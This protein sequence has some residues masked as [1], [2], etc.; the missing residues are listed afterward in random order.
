LQ[1][2]AARRIYLLIKPGLGSALNGSL[3]IVKHSPIALLPEAHE[4]KP[5]MSKVALIQM[6][7]AMTSWPSLGLSLLK[8]S[9]RARGILSEVI[10]LN[11]GFETLVGKTAY[12]YIASGSPCN[13]DLLGE[14]T[15]SEALWEDGSK[16]DAAYWEE[17]IENNHAHFGTKISESDLSKA[18]IYGNLCK[19]NV[20]AFLDQS[21]NDIEWT[22]YKIVGFTSVF[23]QH[24]ASLAFARLLKTLFPHLF[25][26]FGGANCEAEMGAATLRCFPFIDAVCRGE[27]DDIFPLLA[28]GVLKNSIPRLD[29]IL[30]RDQSELNE[31]IVID[32]RSREAKP[33]VDLNSLPY[34]DFDDFFDKAPEGDS[35]SN[36]RLVF[37]T[38]RGCWWGQKHHCT[39][40]GLNG[41]GMAFRNKS[42]ARALEELKWMLSRY[43]SYTRSVNATDNIM[44]YEFFTSFLPELAKLDFDLDLF[45]ET[46]ANLKVEQ[47]EL[48][49]RAGLSRIQPGIES[50]SS[51]V[52]SL[53]EKGVTALQ[54]I[55]LLKLCYELD[56]HPQWNYLYGFPGEDPRWYSLQPNLIDKIS[57]LTPPVGCARVRFDRFSQ[58]LNNPSKFGLKQTQPYA[59]Y[60]RIYRGVSARDLRDLAYYF[61]AS[62]EGENF[63]EK[64]TAGASAA[65]KRWQ[66]RNRK[67]CLF[68]Q[69]SP[70]NTVVYDSRGSAE[71]DVVVLQGTHHAV[72]SLCDRI[73]SYAEV[74]RGV[75]ALNLEWTSG[76]QVENAIRD[77]EERNLLISENSKLLGLSVP[78]EAATPVTS[79][80]LASFERMFEGKKNATPIV[81]EGVT[82]LGGEYEVLG[83]ETDRKEVIAN[84]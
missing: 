57:H 8:S 31:L 36:L 50:L 35:A 5:H 24:V 43:G 18:R 27:G 61:I 81:G 55:Q 11:R 53:M 49:K 78:L 41:N 72:A 2:E 65:V 6:P 25:L 28:D 22:Q 70:D 20:K 33:V 68:H 17:T 14:W 79:D 69:R 48:Y 54:N 45:Y 76:E 3:V 1:R 19:T 67:V 16:S 23:Q 30:L 15:F 46:K 40:C 59:S 83:V 4:M 80:V 39:F 58:Y 34:P 10:Y 47:L 21:L 44:P 63:I 37:E 64:Y 56:I 13:T 42:A 84:G 74:K 51:E 26:V 73:S 75:A 12:E 66:L 9:L 71:I 82:F 77:L 38:S 52:L 7:Y 62:F 29:G 60:R 32:H